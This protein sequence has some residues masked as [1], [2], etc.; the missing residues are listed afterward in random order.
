MRR[1]NP[2]LAE[3]KKLRAIEDRLASNRDFFSCEDAYRMVRDKASHLEARASILERGLQ[4]VPRVLR[5]LLTLRYHRYS[6]GLYSAV[7]DLRYLSSNRAP[8]T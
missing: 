5:E 6:R 1:K 7:K 8:S 2:F 3:I 4:S